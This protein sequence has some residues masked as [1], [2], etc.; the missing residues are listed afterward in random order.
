[1]CENKPCDNCCHEEDLICCM[2]MMH[3]CGG[4][5][6]HN[7]CCPHNRCC[8]H[9]CCCD[10]GCPFTPECCCCKAMKCCKENKKKIEEI[11]GD[12]NN[13]NGEIIRLEEKHDS[14][15][16][17]IGQDI[18][19][20]AQ[21]EQDDINELWANAI[22]NV[23]YNSGTKYITYKTRNGSPINVVKVAPLDNSDKIPAEYLPSYVDDVIEGYYYNNAFYQ[24]AAHTA[25]ITGEHG[26]IYVDLTSG[27]NNTYR[28]VDN[29]VGYIEVSPTKFGEVAGTAYEG[30][31]GKALESGLSQ[32]T[33]NVLNHFNN[34]DIHVMP[35]R[36]AAWNAKADK[37]QIGQ[38]GIIYTAQ[39]GIIQIPKYP[40]TLD[41]IVDG[42]TRKLSDYVLKNEIGTA[43]YK[44]VPV[45]GNA[46]TTQVVM[47]NDSRLT[48][49][50]TPVSH[51]HTKSEI[52][53]FPTNVSSFTNDAG[54]ITSSDIPPIPA[55]QIQSDWNQSNTN[56]LDYI[57]NKPSWIGNTKPTYTLDEVSDGSTRKLSDYAKKVKVGQSGTEL[58]PD[59][60]GV[61]TL[62]EYP[63]AS[64]INI[65]IGG[66]SYNLETLL[67]N[68]TN[69]I[70]ALKDLWQKT[71]D[72]GYTYL[73][74]VTSTNRVR[75][76]GFYDTTVS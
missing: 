56:S 44:D 37:I 40:S 63:T 72:G 76:Y 32:L 41:D 9:P 1:M 10:D 55:A 69:D 51:T 31:K 6:E 48:D 43:A 22:I 33:S 34:H 21:N 42:S 25:P 2:P 73:E 57:K 27:G 7:N 68:I 29:Q 12:I 5:S 36:A 50:R 71:T 39:Q 58:A 38:N 54:Y 75:G 74:P 30:N 4:Y 8:N 62:P 47:G 24:D 13:I 46:S 16:S 66:T 35:D 61:V 67:T 19:E 45:T 49:A 26:K 3:C 11:E 23:A 53:D 65:T 17:G 28:Y 64:S 20:L 52:T 70:T 60:N 14:D 59:N 18:A 15:I